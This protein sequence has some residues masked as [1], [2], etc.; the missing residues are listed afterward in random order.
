MSSPSPPTRRVVNVIGLL[1][2]RHPVPTR[3]SDVVHA[4]GLNKATAHAILAELCE[5]GWVTRDPADKAFFIGNELGRIA[6]QF[7]Q[8]RSVVHAAH[9]AAAA[10]G[11]EF[12]YA[13]SV[14]ERVADSLVISAFI[15]GGDRQWSVAVGDRLPFAAPFG[16][17]YAAWESD[18]QRHAWVERSGVDIAGF[19]ERQGE[20]LEQIRVDGYS[21]E[22]L[23]PETV[24][25]IP[26]MTRLHADAA[27]SSMRQNLNE[28]LMELSGTAPT[29]RSA[30]TQPQQEYVGAI[31][32]PV[33]D[34]RG[35]VRFN[36]CVHPF[37]TLPS[38]RIVHIGRHLSEAAAAITRRD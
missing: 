29:S 5:S 24:S 22:R 16:P 6:A 2:E 1:A 31:T 18:A 9:A 35:R 28:I 10:A 34:D 33:F 23:S 3:L 17:A 13:A 30:Q 11:R 15:P 37:T 32:A 26:V 14:S 38:Q 20:K 4:L 19:A 8:T 25:A 7:D 36:I 27:S 21:V 12:G